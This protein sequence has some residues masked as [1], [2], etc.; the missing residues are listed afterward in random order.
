MLSTFNSKT[1][2]VLSTLANEFLVMDKWFSSIPGLH[3]TSREIHF[4]LG[5]TEVNRAY[6]M[7]A[8][9]H[10][11][12]DNDA[13]TLAEGF[14]QDCFQ[15]LLSAAGTNHFLILRPRPLTTE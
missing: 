11:T 14:P 13:W 7:S 4:V 9:S 8:S 6:L 15:P 1:L 5:P 12:A 3:S 10:G 2:P